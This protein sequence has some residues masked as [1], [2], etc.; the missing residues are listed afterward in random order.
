MP[1]LKLVLFA[2]TCFA[3]TV[4]AYNMFE[5][6]TSS[7]SL[8]EYKIGEIA[9]MT[10]YDAPEPLQAV[11]LILEDGSKYIL[12]GKDGQILLVNLWASW[13]APCIKEMPALDRLQERLG[14]DKFE[15]VAI[16]VDVKGVAKAREYMDNLELKH[17]KLYAD[18]TMAAAY[19]LA[20]GRLPTSHVIDKN[21]NV[22]ASYLGALEWD[23]DDAIALFEHLI[24][25]LE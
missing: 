3:V 25:E 20:E 23:S 9:N 2:I 5:R 13:C 14:G 22:V 17:L 1:Q 8:I 15:V 16:N 11:N 19:T 21:G 10:F 4:I 12:D 7:S 6:S 24:G 18:P